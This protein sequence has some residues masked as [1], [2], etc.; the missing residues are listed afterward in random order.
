MFLF[1]TW[2]NDKET[3][4]FEKDTIRVISKEMSVTSAWRQDRWTRPK[5][6]Y[7]LFDFGEGTLEM[8]F[9]IYEVSGDTLRLEK[10]HF[11]GVRAEDYPHIPFPD[12]FTN[13]QWL[14]IKRKKK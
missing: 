14:F 7:L 3:M 4:I 12:S 5:R 9:A 8:P 2:K 10:T 11:E 13:K 1:G 6:I